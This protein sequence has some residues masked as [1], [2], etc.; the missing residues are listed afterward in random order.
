MQV[1]I[2]TLFTI[3]T[4]LSIH[5]ITRDLRDKPNQI[6][7][8]LCS[9][10]DTCD[11]VA[12]NKGLTD[13]HISGL[14]LCVKVHRYTHKAVTLSVLLESVLAVCPKVIVAECVFVNAC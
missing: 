8:Y 1:E 11:R 10:Y 5:R 4:I 12:V 7:C 13:N 9:I 14:L 6:N 2:S 3:V